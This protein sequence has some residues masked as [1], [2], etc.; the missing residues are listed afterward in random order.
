MKI[1]LLLKLAS[2]I[3]PATILS[4]SMLATA[5][6][7]DP[8]T[9][10]PIDG[11]AMYPI[12]F[13]RIG[14]IKTWD[15]YDG[16]LSWGKGQTMAALDDGCDMTVSEWK[17]K[18]PWGPK[19]VAGYDAVDVDDDPS[20]VPP[21]YHGTSIAFPSS[22][23]HNGKLGVAFNNSVIQIRAVSIVHLRRDE[24]ATIARALQWV[25]DNQK[26][27]NITAINLSPVDDKQHDGPVPTAIDEKL[28]RLREQGVWVSAPCGN[29]GHTTGISWPA[30]A[31]ACFAIGAVKPDAYEVVHLDRFSNTDLTVPAYATSSANAIIVG[32][33]MIL[34]EA[35]EKSGFRWRREAKTLPQAM[36]AIFQKT[37]TEVT[38]PATGLSFRRPNLLA[39][40]DYVFSASKLRETTAGNET[41]DENRIGRKKPKR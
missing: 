13:D 32:S 20:P 29:N 19:V 3:Y 37:G 40:V 34:R 15:K 6:A 26:R 8:D 31:S 7:E 14:V 21:G 2:I 22:L 10:R 35:I 17:A 12:E 41:D 36:M 5:H 39:A 27:Y 38:D 24:S 11:Q 4:A 9:S 30:C 16:I 25:I 23:N 18:L 33:A 28:A 1:L